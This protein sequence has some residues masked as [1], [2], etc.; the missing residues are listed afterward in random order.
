MQASPLVLSTHS[1]YDVP[2]VKSDGLPVPGAGLAVVKVVS[3]LTS[4]TVLG[5]TNCIWQFL[6]VALPVVPVAF[7]QEMPTIAAVVVE[8][9]MTARPAVIVSGIPR[10]KLC[11]PPSGKAKVYPSAHVPTVLAS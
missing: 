3:T 11:E 8:A 9:R 4:Q 1:E 6:L 10:R 5:N 2:I 7:A